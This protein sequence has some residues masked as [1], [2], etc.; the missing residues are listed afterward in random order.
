L[1]R[2]PLELTK[3]QEDASL[4]SYLPVGYFFIEASTIIMALAAPKTHR[5][6]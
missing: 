2:I 4:G 5:A 1:Y 3:L 6:F